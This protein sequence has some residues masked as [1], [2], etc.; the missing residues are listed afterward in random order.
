MATMCT[1]CLRNPVLGRTA[2][3][4]HISA[5]HWVHKQAGRGKVV[6]EAILSRGLN[7]KEKG[8]VISMFGLLP[9]GQNFTLERFGDCLRK[10]GDVSPIWHA[11]Y[12]PKWRD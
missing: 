3:P 1:E 4:H 8:H 5:Q 10:F 6:W 9:E 11:V 7:H 12:D 2:T